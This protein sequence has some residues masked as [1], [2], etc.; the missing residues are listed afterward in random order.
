MQERQLQLQQQG[1]GHLPS[2][3][4][5]A[6]SDDYHGQFKNSQRRIVRLD[7][8]LTVLQREFDWNYADQLL[9]AREG[10]DNGAPDP[11]VRGDHPQNK[12]YW[13]GQ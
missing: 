13:G 11:H 12:S 5:A 2:Q 9:P 6:F 7:I 3:M 8:A 10:F 1:Q 4:L